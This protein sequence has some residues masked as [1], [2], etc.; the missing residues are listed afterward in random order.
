[1]KNLYNILRSSDN[2]LETARQ[3]VAP[4]CK[5]KLNDHILNC[6][7]CEFMHS[8]KN[9]CYGN[10]NANILI[11]AGN[12]T[13]S[14]EEQ[15]Y[16]NSIIDNSSINKNDIFV[17][18]SVNCICKRKSGDD[19]INRDPSLAELNN[20]SHFI[21]YAIQ[22]IRPRIIISMGATALNQ[23]YPQYKFLDYIGKTLNYD[24]IKAIITYSVNDLFILS[25]RIDSEKVEELVYQTIE[26]FNE[27]QNY[28]NIIK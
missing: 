3:L 20:C 26:S 4:I 28:M 2:P 16:F 12:A 8:G 25:E 19:L 11:I 27:A 6:N 23:F 1:M 15:D 14:Q 24:G 7:E 13:D 17:I 5:D 18:H 9:I 21:K 10:P 22:F